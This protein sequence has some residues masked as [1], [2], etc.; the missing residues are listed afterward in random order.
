MFID[1]WHSLEDFTPSAGDDVFF[2]VENE[3][4]FAGRYYKDGFRMADGKRIKES[5]IKAWKYSSPNMNLNSYPANGERV[6]IPLKEGMVTGVYNDQVGKLGVLEIDPVYTGEDYNLEN[7]IDFCDCSDGWSEVPEP[8]TPEMYS[9]SSTQPSTP[10]HWEG[11][12]I[13]PEDVNIKSFPGKDVEGIVPVDDEKLASEMGQVTPT[14]STDTQT[15]TQVGEI[16]VDPN[17]GIPEHDTWSAVS[18]NGT[19]KKYD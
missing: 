7:S 14:L 17:T 11:M 6:A 2:Y 18:Y 10:T 15:E 8:P 12:E 16:K 13:E 4:V 5:S 1:K 3:G 19:L 9:S